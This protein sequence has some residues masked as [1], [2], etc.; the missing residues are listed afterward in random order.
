MILILP[1]FSLKNKAEADAIASAL[2]NLNQEVYLHTWQHWENPN[3]LWNPSEEVEKIKVRITEPYSIVA[4][5]IGTLIAA[6]LVSLYQPEKV[7][8]MGIPINDMSPQE[9]NYYNNV[10]QLKNLLVIQNKYDTHGSATQVDALLTDVQYK[11]LTKES[12]DH[13]YPYVDEIIS[14]LELK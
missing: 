3:V 10:K 11:L 8:L 7:I 2:E 6:E 13:S 4:K 14:F 1:G 5:S 9:L 12:S